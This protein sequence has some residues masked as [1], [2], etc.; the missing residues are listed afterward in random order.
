MVLF[1]DLL[2]LP[3]PVFPQSFAD[4]FPA[5]WS[6]KAILRATAAG[7]ALLAL[8]V[9]FATRSRRANPAVVEVPDHSGR[10]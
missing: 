7:M 5:G 6:Q 2:N 9:F 3:I 10:I 8:V 4:L 1:G